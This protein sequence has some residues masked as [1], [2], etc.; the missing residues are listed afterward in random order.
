MQRKSHW[1]V[2]LGIAA[3]ATLTATQAALADNYPTRPVRVITLTAPGG[4]LDILAR[5]LAQSL[6]EAA[7]QQ[8]YVENKVG[9]GGNLG[10]AEL[11]RSPAD[12]YTI[13][14]ITVS[15]HGI[16]PGLLGSKLPF[17]A[18]KDF[19]L[20]AVAAELKNAVVVNPKVPAKNMQELVRYA[21]DNPGKVSFGSAG[22]GTSQHMAGELFKH[23]AKID[24]SHVPYRGAAQAAPDLVAGEIQLM[25]SSIPDVL[26]FIQS[27]KLRGIGISTKARSAVLPDL[28]PVA[29]QGFPDFDVKAWFG[30]AAPRGTPPETVA[31]L[32]RQ[33]NAALAKPDVRDRLSKIGM[34]P[35]APLTPDQTRDFVRREIDQWTTV[36]KAANI[37]AQ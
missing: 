28:V 24:I 5:T 30:L 9:A 17:D 36:V 22:I 15:T 3:V 4:S 18:L 31:Y 6:S 26:G 16:N 33:I 14:M 19:E 35:S 11:A 7:G 37:R 10:V 25:F 23:Q 29:E 12:G 21:R 1:S 27:E 20:L 2:A 34:D 8:F 32:N 13:G